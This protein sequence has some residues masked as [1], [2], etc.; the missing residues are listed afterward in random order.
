VF[1]ARARKAYCEYRKEIKTNKETNPTTTKKRKSP[2]NVPIPSAKKFSKQK[3]KVR[4]VQQNKKSDPVSPHNQ[5]N[6]YK[7]V[8]RK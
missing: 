7:R 2:N 3:Q 1:L 5:S 6:Q 4:V 8:I